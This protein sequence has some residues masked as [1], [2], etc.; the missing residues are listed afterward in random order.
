MKTAALHTRRNK[1]ASPPA[2][3]DGLDSSTPDTDALQRPGRPGGG[4][5]SR[6]M[7]AADLLKL[8][9]R[10]GLMVAVGG[11]TFGVLLVVYVILVIL[12][13]LDPAHHG[14]AGGF[15]GFQGGAEA[16]A[17]LGM[18]AGLLLG[19][20]VGAEDA[21]SGILPALVATGRSRVALFLARLPAGLLILVPL[22]ALAYVPVVVFGKGVAG[23]EVTPSWPLVIHTGLWIEL[24]VVFVFLLATGLGAATGSRSSTVGALLVL[25]LVGTPILEALHPLPDV[26]QLLFGLPLDQSQPAGLDLTGAPDANL[27]MSSMTIVVELV[28]WGVLAV[29]AGIWRTVAADT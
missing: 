12:Q 11:I 20:T 14:A 3:A 28:A 24:Q 4:I 2:D 16:L 9:R 27:T 23:G 19:A 15:D 1:R 22:V 8:R 13:A 6:R 7:I 25:L 5:P 10:R 17:K 18:V 29:V 26:R 21:A